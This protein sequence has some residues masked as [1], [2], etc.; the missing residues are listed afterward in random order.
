MITCHFLVNKLIKTKDSKSTVYANLIKSTQDLFVRAINYPETIILW[1]REILGWCR[2]NTRPE[3]EDLKDTGSCL[4]DHKLIT[5]INWKRSLLYQRVQSISLPWRRTKD[6]FLKAKLNFPK[7]PN[8]RL[9]EIAYR[10]CVFL[11]WRAFHLYH[12]DLIWKHTLIDI[13]LHTEWIERALPA[14]LRDTP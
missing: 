3:I 9:R 13:I 5:W 4:C 11:E 14:R 1:N 12:F 8:S 10:C 2:W 7:I 6:V